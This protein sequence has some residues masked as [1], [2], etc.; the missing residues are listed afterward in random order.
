MCGIF[1]LVVGDGTQLS[2]N[3]LKIFRNNAQLAARRGSD[4]S[5]L[6]SRKSTGGFE[7]MKSS[8]SIERLLSDP[9]AKFGSQS[10]IDVLAG[11]S[12]LETHGFS[13]DSSNNQPIIFDGWLVIHNGII[14]NHEAI[15]RASENH[16]GPF[17][18]SDSAA[19]A[20]L[21]SN[22]VTNGRTESIDE[23]VFG[24]CE[25][26]L[27]VLAFS[28]WGE[29]V[30]FTN[31]GN[32]Y[33]ASDTEGSLHIGS[34]PRQLSHDKLS[35]PAQFA[36]NTTH[37]LSSKLREQPG[38]FKILESSKSKSVNSGAKGLHLDESVLESEFRAAVRD[39]SDVVRERRTEVK[40]CSQCLL[41]TTF[42]GLMFNEQQICEL[43]ER[44]SR[45]TFLGADRLKNALSE[46]SPDG[47]TV[48]VCLSGGRDSCYVLHLVTELGFK[49]LAY[50]YDW[51][52]VTTAARENMARMCGKLSVEHI[53]VSPNISLNRQRVGR[54]LRAWIRK[55]DLATVPILMAGDKPYFRFSQIV[56]AERGGIPAVM[57][58]HHLET[59]GFKSS[60]AGAR[61]SFDAEGGVRYRQNT[62]SLLRMGLRYVA[63]AIKNP[64]FAPA[65]FTEGS[66][67][68]I[69]YY[70][71][72]HQFVRPFE[73][74]EWN[75]SEIA[76]VLENEYQWSKGN[77]PDLP[78]WRMGDAT[79][80]FYNLVYLMS[81]GMSEHDALRSNQ[82][83]YGLVTRSE[84]E[85][86]C[87]SENEPNALGLATYFATAGFDQRAATDSL[88]RLLSHARSIRRD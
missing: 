71:R 64:A 24:R 26:E 69:D 39:L 84:A 70:L 38:E 81:L 72:K 8:G 49:P 14:T 56:A 27:S 29:V 57:A 86:L 87:E 1:G 23:A 31:V 12:R 9:R 30:L 34:E 62:S 60:L 42:P 75:E 47:K 79:A 40:R 2:E 35:S 28:A 46:S 80:P 59:T 85:R 67:G 37:V 58:D 20:V 4:A 83:R 3:S 88:Q 52:M 50:T 55:P 82:I 16:G 63:G 77:D 36:L 21:L 10:D 74:V 73:Y 44:F 19:I 33:F 13:A 15:K 32:L 18:E 54:A 22:W 11:H 53:L 51:G 25:G 61:L 48:L 78:A 6:V 65:V 7:I 66:R 45:P 5:G 43:C 17:P 76:Q 68:F 41:P